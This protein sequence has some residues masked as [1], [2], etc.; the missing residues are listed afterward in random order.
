[1]DNRNLIDGGA[2]L[3][4]AGVWSEFAGLNAIPRP[5]KKEEQI[6][7]YL[8]NWLEVRGIAY[9]EDAVGNLLA[10][11]PASHGLENSVP[12][13]LQAH[14]DMV[15]Q[16]NEGTGHDFERQGIDMYVD[17]GWVRARGTTLGADNGMGL[18]MGLAL[19]ADSSAVHPALELLITVDEETGMTGALGLETGWVQGKFLLNLDTEDDRELTVGCAG[20]IDVTAEGTYTPS[21][22]P[23]G[24][25]GLELR[26]RGLTGGHSGMDIHLGRGNANVLSARLLVALE[27]AACILVA[28]WEGGSLRNAI[29]REAKTVVAVASSHRQKALD[30]LTK[31]KDELTSEYLLTDSGLTLEWKEVETPEWSLDPVLQG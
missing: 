1:M 8:K 13:V 2:H 12:V 16:Q 28:E 27:E 7:A 29:P 5:S 4:P 14:M 23:S 10:Y 24:Y 25:T 21:R 22:I 15:C 17:N 6:R 31:V 20:G 3:E 9:R 19:L 30:C 26:L 11:K 18:A